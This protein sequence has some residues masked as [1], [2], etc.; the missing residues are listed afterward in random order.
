MALVERPFTQPGTELTVHV[1]GVERKAKVIAPSPYDP[2]GA[3]MR[4]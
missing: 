3:R 4:L 1:V 2:D